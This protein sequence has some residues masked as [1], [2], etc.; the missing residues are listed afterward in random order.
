MLC[1]KNE[2]GFKER[3][4]TITFQFPGAKLEL[5]VSN[6]MLEMED[7]KLCFAIA[8]GS[9]AIFGNLLQTSYL[10]GYDLEGKTLSFKKTDCTKI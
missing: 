6:T 8:P 9:T 5:G 1:Y 4:P 2:E 3:V 10:V 7:G